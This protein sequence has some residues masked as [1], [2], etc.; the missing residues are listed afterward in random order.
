M[1]DDEA[2]RLSATLASNRNLFQQ[3]HRLQ[4]A[5]FWDPATNEFNS[6]TKACEKK[7]SETF[8]AMVPIAVFLA[9][10]LLSGLLL[11]VL[12]QV[13]K[14]DLMCQAKNDLSGRISQLFDPDVA[15][16]LIPNKCSNP[17]GHP[18]HLRRFVG[19][20]L[21]GSLL[22]SVLT[23]LKARKYEFPV[24]A[25]D[26]LFHRFIQQGLSAKWTV[27]R[28]FFCSLLANLRFHVIYQRAVAQVFPS[29]VIEGHSAFSEEVWVQP[30]GWSQFIAEL[31]KKVSRDPRFKQIYRHHG[32]GPIATTGKD[33]VFLYLAYTARQ[34]LFEAIIKDPDFEF[35]CNDLQPGWRKLWQLV[36]SDELSK[37]NGLLPLPRAKEKKPDADSQSPNL[38]TLLVIVAVIALILRTYPSAAP[39]AATTEEHKNLL[40]A[41]QAIKDDLKTALAPTQCPQPVVNLPGTIQVNVTDPDHRAGEPVQSGTLDVKFGQP[42]VKFE[43]LQV[44]FAEPKVSFDP[45][46]VNFGQAT[47]KFQPLPI[48][49]N[50][51]GG[52]GSGQTDGSGGSGGS[53]ST[54]DGHA[55]AKPGP[56]AGEDKP[57]D[58][59]IILQPEL[60]KSETIHLVLPVAKAG[61]PTANANGTGNAEKPPASGTAANGAQQDNAKEVAAKP[62]SGTKAGGAA[63]AANA[64]S[65]ASADAQVATHIVSCSYTANATANYPWRYPFYRT[66]AVVAQLTITEAEKAKGCPGSSQAPIKFYASRVPLYNKDLQAYISIDLAHGKRYLL[67]GKKALVIR[68]HHDVAPQAAAAVVAGQ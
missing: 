9:C 63:T 54:G 56:R 46:Q 18:V 14:L 31:V 49:W 58:D 65:A 62:D 33:E 48:N 30:E 17:S 3:F 47:V 43:P 23:Y 21:L 67:A 50:G 8:A 39:P 4:E 44:N 5:P 2:E 40:A 24:H 32:E 27:S 38:A 45:L 59:Y 64:P 15:S 12:A 22:V 61:A 36:K 16:L 1:T 29:S 52:A 19:F 26:P 34:L 41:L 53:G 20:A 57:W 13:P 7:T 35:L 6:S 66:D 28:R 37:L 51:G 60:D 55:P 42:T 25:V 68:L 10:C 11:M